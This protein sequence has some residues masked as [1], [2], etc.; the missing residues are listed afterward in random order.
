M[1]EYFLTLL[2]RETLVGIN[3]TLPR[4]QFLISLG[5]T[6]RRVEERDALHHFKPWLATSSVI[7]GP[8]GPR[9]LMSR[10]SSYTLCGIGNISGGSWAP[11]ASNAR[12][13][14]VEQFRPK[15]LSAIPPTTL[16]SM[17]LSPPATSRLLL[18]ASLTV[19]CSVPSKSA[20]P[21]NSIFMPTSAPATSPS[22]EPL[23]HNRVALPR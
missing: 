7:I 23:H 11:P 13:A 2:E 16:A 8:F 5:C 22:A 6:K 14:V 9:S 1:K 3:V 15:R 12:I 10:A 19:A 17:R 20:A 18:S 4:K 21:A